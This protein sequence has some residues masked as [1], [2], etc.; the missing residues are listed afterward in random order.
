M[1]D[2]RYEFRLFEVP[3]L[4]FAA[5]RLVGI[6][7]E[8]ED[9]YVPLVALGDVTPMRTYLGHELARSL[10]DYVSEDEHPGA[11]A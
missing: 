7:S 6:E 5:A 3:K 2:E 11:P 10:A 8:T 9:Q 4:H 1:G